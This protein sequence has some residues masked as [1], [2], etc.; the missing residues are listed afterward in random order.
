MAFVD[1]E[2]FKR[3]EQFLTRHSRVVAEAASRAFEAKGPGVLI[4]HAPDDRFD[5]TPIAQ[6]KFQYKTKV[7]IDRVH[8]D[9]RDELLQGMLDRYQP[10]GEAVFV[11]LYR[12]NTYDISRVV[13]RPAQSSPPPAN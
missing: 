7:E 3:F 2:R 5:D 1:P 10:P 11:A 13:L 6:F 8:A 4:Y 12:D 9:T